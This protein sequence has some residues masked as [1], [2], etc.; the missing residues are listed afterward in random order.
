MSK[1]FFTLSLLLVPV[2]IGCGPDN[3]TTII[4]PEEGAREMTPEEVEEY[5]KNSVKD[6]EP[7]RQD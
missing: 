4:Q 3:S 7:V 2:F 5:N 1:F 6:W